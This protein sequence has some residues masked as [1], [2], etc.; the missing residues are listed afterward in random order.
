[1]LI[2]QQEDII[3]RE[4]KEVTTF[5]KELEELD[6]EWKDLKKSTGKLKRQM[7]RSQESYEDAQKKLR[8]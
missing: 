6:T 4:G 8:K 1:M 2:G 5:E 3:K 7:K